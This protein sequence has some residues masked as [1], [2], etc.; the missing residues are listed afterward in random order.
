MSSF[1]PIHFCN[2]PS[3][4]SQPAVVLK[5][6]A[7]LDPNTGAVLQ[8]NP[9]CAAPNAI[10]LVILQVRACLAL[11][12][13]LSLSFLAIEPFARQLQRPCCMAAF[14]DCPGENWNLV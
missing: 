10:A 12:Q 14:A 1:S 11:I 13:I 4:M 5:L 9:R 8:K 7:L 6:R 2:P 3:S